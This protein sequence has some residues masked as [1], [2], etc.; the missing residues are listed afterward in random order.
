MAKQNKPTKALTTNDKNKSIWICTGLNM[1]SVAKYP[2]VFEYLKGFDN[3]RKHLLLNGGTKN[4]QLAI[5][6]YVLEEVRGLLH[7]DDYHLFV[8]K[9]ISCLDTYNDKLKYELYNNVTRNKEDILDILRGK[10]HP[11]REGLLDSLGETVKKMGFEKYYNEVVTDLEKNNRPKE[12]LDKINYK[13]I[14]IQR[15]TIEDV[16]VLPIN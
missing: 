8:H 4:E 9:E 3:N 2:K 13:E 14:S 5:M 7:P 15:R 10:Y 1:P 6:L 11:L 12:T 16:G